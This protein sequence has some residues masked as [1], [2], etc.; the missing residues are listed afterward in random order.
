MSYFFNTKPPAVLTLDA[1]Q[2]DPSGLY[3]WKLGSYGQLT[4]LP[5]TIALS[6]GDRRP[7][8]GELQ[9]ARDPATSGSRLAELFERYRI[10]VICATLAAHPELPT[11]QLSQLMERGYVAAWLNP[12]ASLALLSMELNS[13]SSGARRA[14]HAAMLGQSD[15][16]E[17][18]GLSRYFDWLR[19]QDGWWREQ[20]VQARAL[21]RIV[22][23]LGAEPS[24]ALNLW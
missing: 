18:S 24:T 9:E 14:L 2:F 20:V 13:A 1:P 12:G 19:D 21:A 23:R 10:G 7:S 17:E 8:L 22:Q 16:Y 15:A 11:A 4:S 5:P 6:L 3:T